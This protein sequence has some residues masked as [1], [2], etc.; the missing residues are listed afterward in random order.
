MVIRQFFIIVIVSR[1]LILLKFINGF[2]TFLL[3]I[4]ETLRSVLL[5]YQNHVLVCL[6]GL[7]I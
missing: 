2:L 3:T 5:T 6:L 4:Y 1:L 7:L